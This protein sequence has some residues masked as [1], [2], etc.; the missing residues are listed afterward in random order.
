[1]FVLFVIVGLV[2]LGKLMLCDCMVV[3]VLG[4]FCVVMMMMCFLWL[5]EVDGVYYYFF[6]L[7]EFDEKI[8]VGVFFEWVWVYKKNCYGMFVV[9]VFGLLSE[10]CSLIINVDV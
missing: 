5:G 4:F 8:V 9:D 6:M 10:G 2:G 1:M 3:E 7:V